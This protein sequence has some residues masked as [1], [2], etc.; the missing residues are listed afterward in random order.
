MAITSTHYN[1]HCPARNRLGIHNGHQIKG[2]PPKGAARL[3]SKWWTDGRTDGQTV[4]GQQQLAEQLQNAVPTLYL[5]QTSSHPDSYSV[6]GASACCSIRAPRRNFT[7][8]T[9]PGRI[10]PAMPGLPE[11]PRIPSQWVPATACTCQQRGIQTLNPSEGQPWHRDFLSAS[12]NNCQTRAKTPLDP[13][14][15]SNPI[16]ATNNMAIGCIMHAGRY[17]CPITSGGRAPNAG[18]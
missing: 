13:L 12:C 3:T 11:P 18:G 16:A 17:I 10:C 1:A 15:P 8:P 2:M 5:P 14:T 4:G 6:Y 9:P 7:S